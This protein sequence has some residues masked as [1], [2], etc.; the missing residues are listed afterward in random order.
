MLQA[1]QLAAGARRASRWG[2]ATHNDELLRLLRGRCD[3]AITEWLVLPARRAAAAELP[4]Q[5]HCQLLPQLLSLLPNTSL[6]MCRHGPVP[7]C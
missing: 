4:P 2:G 3:T 5:S 1:Q 7:L 6:G